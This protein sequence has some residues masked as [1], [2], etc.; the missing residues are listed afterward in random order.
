MEY[1][2]AIYHLINRGDRRE[3]IFRDDDRSRFLETL[4]QACAKT[5]WQVLAYCLMS[6]HFHLGSLCNQPGESPAHHRA[7]T[8]AR[9]ME[10]RRLAQSA[11]R[12]PGESQTGAA[13]AG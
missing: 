13:I 5:G 7:A 4:G 8:Q 1:P 9:G 12:A 6:N 10:G 3:D 11:Q 2:G